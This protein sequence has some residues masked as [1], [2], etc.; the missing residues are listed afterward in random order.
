M[1]KI[2]GTHLIK[3]SKLLSKT[4]L[5]QDIKNSR[6]ENKEDAF[7]LTVDLLFSVLEMLGDQG[8]E[9]ELWELL[10]ELFEADAKEMEL[11]EL[12]KNFKELSKEN[13]L[14]GFF[15]QPTQ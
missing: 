15:T 12:I 13:N 6:K 9:D 11:E 4:N 5:K 14:T 3:M 2:K 7:C 8:L 1:K 10:S